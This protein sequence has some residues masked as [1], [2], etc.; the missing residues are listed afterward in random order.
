MI[1]KMKRL[2]FYSII[3]L[4]FLAVSSCRDDISA[5]GGFKDE[6]LIQSGFISLSI[7]D[8]GF[9]TRDLDLTPGSQL[10][11]NKIWV[12]VYDKKNGNRVWQTDVNL[13]ARPTSSG[14]IIQDAISVKI[15]DSNISATTTDRYVVVGVANYDDE[16][17][18]NYNKDGARGYD[19]LEEALIAADTW[20]DFIDISIDTQNSVFKDNTPMLMGYLYKETIE[21]FTYTKVNQFKP[22]VGINLYPSSNEDNFFVSGTIENGKLTGIS[23]KYSDSNGAERNYI[24][25]LRRMRSKINVNITTPDGLTLTDMKYKVFYAPKSV[26]LAQRRT[27]IFDQDTYKK[28]D[29]FTGSV[30]D[31]KYS[32]NSADVMNEGYLSDDLDLNE[33]WVTAGNNYSFSFYQFEN[34]NWAYN[35]IGDDSMNEIDRYHLRESMNED[36]TFSALYDPALFGEGEGAD[37]NNKASLIVMKATLRNIETGRNAEMIYTVHEGFCNDKDGLSLVKADGKTI[38]DDNKDDESPFDKRLRDFSCIRNTD[39]YYNIEILSAEK[40]RLTVTAGAKHPIDQHGSIWE[41]HNVLPDRYISSHTEKSINLETPV[42]LVDD[43]GKDIDF[44]DVAFRI[45]GSV[46]DEARNV[47]K[48]VDIC[49]NFA[50]GDLDGFA[51]LWPLPTSETTYLVETT[52]TDSQTDESVTITAYE[53][54]LKYFDDNSNTDTQG[55]INARKLIENIKIRVPGSIDPVTVKD[56]IIGLNEGTLQYEINGFKF[57]GFTY[58]DIYNPATDVPRDNL[59][60]LYII[61]KQKAMTEGS[62]A[63]SY[64]QYCNYYIIDLAAEQYPAYIKT[65]NFE[66]KESLVRNNT[67]AD[68]TGGISSDINNGHNE[69]NGGKGMIFTQYPDL[70]FRLLGYDKDKDKYF[71]L[72][73][74]FNPDTETYFNEFMPAYDNRTIRINKGY[75]NADN[76]NIPTSLLEGIKVVY[77]NSTYTIKEFIARSESGLVTAPYDINFSLGQYVFD[78]TLRTTSPEIYQRALYI[79]DK[80]NK[81]RKPVIFDEDNLASTYQI[82]SIKQIPKYEQQIKLTLP[83]LSAIKFT[84]TAKYDYVEEFIG[85]LTLPIISGAIYDQDYFYQVIIDGKSTRIAGTVNGNN[86]TCNIPMGALPGKSGN[87]RLQAIA[88]NDEFESSQISTNTVGSVSTLS[89][90]SW[91]FTVAN[92]NQFFDLT[93]WTG[94]NPYVFKNMEKTYNFLTFYTGATQELRWYPG[95][96]M[97]FNNTGNNCRMFTK[98]YKDCKVNVTVT[99]YTGAATSLVIAGDTT[100]EFSNISGTKTCSLDVTVNETG[101]QNVTINFSV[102]GYITKI[103]IE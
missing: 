8:A 42:K 81:N 44:D 71:D 10:Y 7:D 77:D 101:S 50:R 53:A 61:D 59:K 54:L 63:K 28:E 72:C 87:I 27:N 23:T 62:R 78:K 90:P 18:A 1:I 85:T 88:L 89:N 103:S 5:P 49:Y 46:Y 75:L 4:V 95:Q 102:K 3:L 83:A 9:R 100:E 57:D 93:G 68:Y 2:Y 65:E 30:Y 14:S 15:K 29:G 19:T 31:S 22:S 84:Q 41:I 13:Y 73:Y 36:G 91:D 70:A 6:D 64:D 47:E 96:Y 24:L 98:V 92:G 26:F 17:Y 74:N 58:Y 66:N 39:Y 34:K 80:K 16:I 37:W 48:N 76:S 35:S 43:T 67:T 69:V 51:G 60:G 79:F 25:K 12:G 32:A 38:D 11:L 82:Y 40:I 45:V 94:S 99:Q 56:Y 20:D 52:L 97:Y 55:L 21:N 33:G 86:I